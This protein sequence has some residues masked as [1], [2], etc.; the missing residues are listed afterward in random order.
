MAAVHWTVCWGGLR[1]PTSH[2]WGIQ[3]RAATTT[4]LAHNSDSSGD[5]ALRDIHY[6]LMLFYGKT[7]VYI[8]SNSVKFCCDVYI[9]PSVWPPGWYNWMWVCLISPLN[10]VTS[11]HLLRLRLG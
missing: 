4:H 6:L 8:M 2:N 5:H 7:F 11:P 3:Y 1:P 10:S 9:K